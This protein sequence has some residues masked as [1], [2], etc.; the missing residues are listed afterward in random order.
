[1]K[2]AIISSASEKTSK[3]SEGLTYQ[4]VKKISQIKNIEIMTGG[5][6]GIPGLVVKKAKD[7]GVRTV[8][9]SPDRHINDHNNRFDNLHTEYF[10]EIKFIPGFTARSLQMI[11]DTEK[12]LLLNGSIGTLSE[13]TIALEEGKKVGIITNTGGIADHI[14][15]ILSIAEKEFP[16]Q[17]FFSDDYEEVI[18]WIIKN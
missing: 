12:I 4:I 1:M 13:F 8:A 3:E 5:S 14:E 18:N 15:Y 9:Y 6:L 11:H 7:F 16:G 2:I 10:D 17:V